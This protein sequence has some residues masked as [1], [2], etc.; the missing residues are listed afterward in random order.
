LQAD[1]AA[2]FEEFARLHSKP[3]LGDSEEYARRHEAFK[4]R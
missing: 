3:Y 2:A 1:P 4:V